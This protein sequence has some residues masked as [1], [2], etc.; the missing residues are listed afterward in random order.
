MYWTPAK[1]LLLADVDEYSFPNAGFMIC[2][3]VQVQVFYFP[4]RGCY[5]M[6]TWYIYIAVSVGKV[7]WKA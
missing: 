2:M 7:R 5:L 6:H 4:N 1:M 3:Y